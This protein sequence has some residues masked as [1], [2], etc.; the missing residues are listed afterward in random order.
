VVSFTLRQ[1]YLQGK[2][3]WYPL[4]RRL[5]GIQSRSGSGGEEKNAQPLPGLEHPIIQLVVK[6]YTAE[7]YRLQTQ[8]EAKTYP[9]KISNEIHARS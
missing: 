3:P 7:L 9:L 6:R 1:L 2:S 5:G 4:D 8:K